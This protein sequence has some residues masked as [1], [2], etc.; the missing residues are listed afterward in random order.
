MYRINYLSY[1]MRITGFRLQNGYMTLFKS[2]ESIFLNSG[3]KVDF[4]FRTES[5]R[6]S[7]NKLRNT[8]MG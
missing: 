2:S 1:M 3:K 4:L 8:D 6:L 7:Q 5:L